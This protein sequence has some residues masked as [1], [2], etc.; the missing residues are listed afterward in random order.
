[1]ETVHRCL[2]PGGLSLL[3]TMGRTK[4]MP[5]GNDQWITKYIFPN[6]QVPSVAQIGEA[7]DGLF[8]MED[9]ENLS[10]D[11]ERTLLA[12]QANFA[13]SWT[14]LE[15]GYDG[16]FFRMWSYYL[17][18]CA[19]WYRSRALQ[20][21]QVVLSKDGLPGGYGWQKQRRPLQGKP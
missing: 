19:G 15:A 12:W 14:T 20:L 6:T 11:Y 10:T 21:W 3:H 5:R 2:K 8:V 17:W 13:R 1:M 18:I 4:S 16:R 9:W 7:I